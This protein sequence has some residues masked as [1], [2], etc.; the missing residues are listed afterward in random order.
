MARY[1]IRNLIG[2]GRLWLCNHLVNKIP[3]HHFRLWFYRRIMHF[4]IENNRYIHLGCRFNCKASFVLKK[5]S[6]INQYCHIDHRGGVFI[7]ENVSIGPQ[8]KLITADHDL[9]HINGIG[10]EKPIYIKDY[11]FIGH[12]ALILGETL[13]NIGSAVGANGVFTGNTE[14]FG[15]Y[16]G[17]PAKLKNKRP[18]NLCYV[19]NYDRLLH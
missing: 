4:T 8:V 7:G 5:N 18:Q 14:P 13:L 11:V 12:S 2:E 1:N 3:R 15:I 19:M 6:T 10:R 9:T 16:I 17:N